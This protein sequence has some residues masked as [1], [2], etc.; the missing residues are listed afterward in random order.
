[1]RSGREEDA[2]C[3]DDGGGE[4]DGRLPGKEA[5]REQEDPEE[6][7]DLKKKSIK[8]TKFFLSTYL[9][10]GRVQEEEEK[11]V[12]EVFRKGGGRRPE[13]IIN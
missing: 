13:K 6:G 11:V 3:Q 8:K 10:S 9:R 1:M 12:E 4:G 7:E 5:N 2:T